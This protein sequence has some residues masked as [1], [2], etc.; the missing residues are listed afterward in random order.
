[1]NI[2]IQVLDQRQKGHR[3]LDGAVTALLE[4]RAIAY[5]NKDVDI[6][7]VSWGPKDDGRTMEAPHRIV[8]SALQQGVLRKC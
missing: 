3:I 4:A 2:M 7:S 8:E 5:R 1:M 6:K